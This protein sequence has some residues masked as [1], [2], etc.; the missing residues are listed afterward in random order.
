VPSTTHGAQLFRIA[1][2]TDP[3]RAWLWVERADVK[4]LSKKIGY[5]M[6]AGDRIPEALEPIITEWETRERT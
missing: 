1:K 4:L 5:V 3:R 6:G 2:S